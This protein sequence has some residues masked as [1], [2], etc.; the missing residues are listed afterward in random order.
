MAG[1]A[2]AG[3]GSVA[4]DGAASGA[5]MPVSPGWPA[6]LS[7]YI[8]Y[9]LPGCC[10]PIGGN[11]PIKEELYLRSGIAVTFGEGQLGKLLNNDAGWIIQGGGRSLFFNPAQDAARTVDLALGHTVNSAE[12]APPILILIGP[13]TAPVRHTVTVKGTQRTNVT[14]ALGREW[15]LN[16]TADGSGG[17]LV[18][19][20]GADAGGRLGTARGD[21]LDTGMQ[22]IRH[23]TDTIYGTVL[24]LH[25]DV[26][27]KC[28]CCCTWM[29]G[30]RAEWDFTWS[31]L[32]KSPNNSDLQDVNFL[33]TIGVRF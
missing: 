12:P 20:A 16:G 11:G 3:N 19:R 14:L 29:A 25:T 26:E 15:Y 24:S 5:G 2:G 31:D 33:G 27:W 32:L 17:G 6:G 18:W 10:G 4:G 7:S 1:D 30:F 28:G 9:S 22:P 8:T 23:L 13:P 21:V